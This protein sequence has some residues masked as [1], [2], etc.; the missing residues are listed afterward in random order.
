MYRAPKIIICLTCWHIGLLIAYLIDFDITEFTKNKASIY[1]SK[2]FIEIFYY[3][4]KSNSIVG[5][6]SCYL[7]YL[8]GGLITLIILIF[9]G[10][11]FGIYFF[12]FLKLSTLDFQHN[13]PLIN[14]FGHV[15]FEIISFSLFGALGLRGFDWLIKLY[16]D[17]GIEI[18]LPS[19]EALLI[20]F[21]ILVFATIIETYAIY[22]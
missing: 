11:L 16:S 17:K 8:S 19:P 7:G 14:L 13:Q 20:P 3:I 1:N 22:H 6:L 12:P 9:N 5:L 2:S 15:P 4:L 18:D 21:L 10:Y